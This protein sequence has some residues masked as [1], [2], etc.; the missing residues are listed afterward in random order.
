MERLSYLI[1][2]SSHAVEGVGVGGGGALSVYSHGIPAIEDGRMESEV[3]RAQLETFLARADWKDGSAILVLPTEAVSFRRLRFSFG[4]TK[5]IRQA[6]PFEL[7]NELMEGLEGF[8]YDFDVVS[9]KEQHTE[10]LVYLVRK[11]TLQGLLEACQ[12]RNLDVRRVTFSAQALL[13]AGK[14]TEGH[15]FH[16]YTGSDETFILYTEQGRLCAM[17][18]LSATPHLV[19]EEAGTQEDA[20]PTERLRVLLESS[21]NGATHPVSGVP[22]E[23]PP[24]G[25]EGE[26][27]PEDPE[28]LLENIEGGSPEPLHPRARLQGEL[29]RAR[30]EANRFLRLY[31]PGVPYG[32]SVAGLFSS[33]LTFRPETGEIA[34]SLE[35]GAGVLPVRPHSGILSELVAG[36]QAL[37]RSGGINFFRR[38]GTWVAVFS[39]LKWKL[40]VSAVL[41]VLLTGLWLGAYFYRGSIIEHRLAGI[42]AQLSSELKIPTPVN[43]L[44]VNA[45]LKKLREE[46]A[47]LEQEQNAA[48]YLENYH[49]D[50]LV[51]LR[52]VS[53]L[54]TQLPRMKVD[55]LTFNR[56][57]F[58]L[59]GTTPDYNDSETLKN[60]IA[61]LE[62]FKGQE[63]KISHSRTGQGIL[64]RLS[65]QRRE[66]P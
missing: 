28:A 32:L 2:L 66:G 31:R 55:A 49:Y 7:E 29:E 37:G 54:F 44:S 24:A 3:I 45:A 15:Q 62:Q 58:T 41:V 43:T 38:V 53:R 6:L 19:L 36:Q 8:V 52:E 51:L 14:N 65:I 23:G 40:V 50:A 46:R 35:N 42:N 17:A 1:A 22:E 27:F 20:S 59:T 9:G 48:A 16:L 60:R 18:A 4:D 63:V 56:D 21:G 57:R 34:L 25:E 12:A 5:K 61:A 30:E 39:A 33:C 10:V 64:Y 47:K 26:E 13:S 11:D